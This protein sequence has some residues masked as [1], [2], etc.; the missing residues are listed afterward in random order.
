MGWPV[1]VI[2]WWA[3]NCSTL[4]TEG[5]SKFLMS[6]LDDCH[7]FC[8]WKGY[9]IWE[10]SESL[11][12]GVSIW[13]SK[14]EIRIYPRDLWAWLPITKHLC[15]GS[16]N[17]LLWADVT[18][19]K[20][21]GAV[22]RTWVDLSPHFCLPGFLQAVTNVYV[23]SG[24]SE[25]GSPLMRHRPPLPLLSWPSWGGWVGFC[26]VSPC[27]LWGLGAGFLEWG[28]GSEFESWPRRICVRMSNAFLGHIYFGLQHCF[29]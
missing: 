9:E 8:R 21:T 5:V 2:V 15:V 4:R 1:L 7:E 22:N 23:S 27:T 10:C 12:L 26:S 14:V 6:G 3:D 20:G 16:R 29:M 17:A 19:P 11:D 25:L 28:S 24:V 18:L 13:S